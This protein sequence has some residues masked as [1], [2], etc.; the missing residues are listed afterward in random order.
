MYGGG[1]AA[2]QFRL[3]YDEDRNKIEPQVYSAY[4]RGKTKLA[5]IL[6]GANR[7]AF[8]LASYWDNHAALMPALPMHGF[9]FERDWG[10]G[11]ARDLA[12]G[13]VSFSLTTGSGMAL[14][15]RGNWL[16]SARYSLGVLGSDN[17]NLGFSLL[18][19]KALDTVGYEVRD[20]RPEDT[21]LLGLDFAANHENIEHKAELDFGE[22]DAG[23]AFAV[24][25]RLGINLM[26]E[27][28]LKL[29]GQ[30]VYTRLG[31]G[32]GHA[33]ATGASYRLSADLGARLM[34]EWRRDM[35]EHRIVLQLYYYSLA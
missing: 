15:G 12:N 28:R 6:V 13:D 11:I 14:E 32:G 17:Y 22:K 30:Y 24:L 26:D 16:A 29:E 4:F 10:M 2:L 7:I 23:S 19:G 3:A 8:G 33:V 31:Q 9:G 21:S 25:Y 5:D 20:G 18:F 34:Y 27:G 35:D 1:R